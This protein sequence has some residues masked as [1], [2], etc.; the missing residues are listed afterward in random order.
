MT[1]SPPPTESPDDDLSTPLLV[2]VGAAS[3][4][5]ASA[6][7]GMIGVQIALTFNGIDGLYRVLHFLYFAVG[8]AGLIFAVLLAR[9]KFVGALGGMLCTLLILGL[10][11]TPSLF[12]FFAL[13]MIGAAGFAGLSALL[14]GVSLLLTRKLEKRRRAFYDTL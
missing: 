13:S 2:N 6:F 11:W 1:A 14:V 3:L 9:G 4:A 8:A 10:F 7:L 12:G 5:I